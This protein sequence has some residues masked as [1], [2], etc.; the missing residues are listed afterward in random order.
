MTGCRGVGERAQRGAIQGMLAKPATVPTSRAAVP[1][2]PRP[3]QKNG[4]REN[5]R[6]QGSFRGAW[7][8]E[9]QVL[10]FPELNCQLLNSCLNGQ[11]GRRSG[12]WRA[13]WHIYLQTP[14]GSEALTA[15]YVNKQEAYEKCHCL[16]P[17]ELTGTVKWPSPQ[18]FAKTRDPGNVQLSV[19]PVSVRVFLCRAPPLWSAGPVGGKGR[20]RHWRRREGRKSSS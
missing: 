6:A 13:S 4:A 16:F 15:S 19:P 9:I 11:R 2:V 1:F 5:R 17:P 3:G 10:P 18:S 12:A 14:I 8:W 20:Q 7:Q